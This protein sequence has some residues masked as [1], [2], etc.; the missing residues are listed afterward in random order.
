MG[1]YVVASALNRDYTLCLGTTIV[2]VTLLTV[3]NLVVDIS[4]AMLDPRLRE[5]G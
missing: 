2:Y 5:Q 3:F 1:S 4:Y